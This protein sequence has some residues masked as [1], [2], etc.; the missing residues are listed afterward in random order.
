MCPTRPRRGCGHAEW[1]GNDARCGWTHPPRRPRW[2]GRPARTPPAARRRRLDCGCE[3]EQQG[4]RDF[5]QVAGACA[6]L[7]LC[8]GHSC[9]HT[10]AWWHPP[11]KASLQAGWHTARLAGPCTCSRHQCQALQH[12]SVRQCCRLSGRAPQQMHALAEASRQSRPPSMHQPVERLFLCACQDVAAMRTMC[13]P[14]LLNP[15]Q[16]T[17]PRAKDTACCAA[18]QPLALQPKTAPGTGYTKG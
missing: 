4:S 14:S 15:S 5:R 12:P 9:M 17:V 1:P 18:H 16:H 13:L 3:R 7:P 6:S 11:C 8:A 10:G 2:A